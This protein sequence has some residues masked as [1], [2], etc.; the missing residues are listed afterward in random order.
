MATMHRKVIAFLAVLAF[1]LP[2][3]ACGGNDSKEGSDG[4][5]ATV[6]GSTVTVGLKEFAIST[7]RA[8]VPA[9]SV[10]FEA[11]NEGPEDE[12]E[13]VVIKTDLGVVG[14][15]TDATGTVDE[16]GEGVEALGEIE[17]F[18]V[19]ET[20]DLTL[21]LAP[22]NYVLICNIYT[23]SENESHYQEGMRTA[24]TVT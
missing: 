9:G 11:T 5:G 7:S 10:T 22:G 12:H 6:E 8:S 3:T 24:F 4:G 16:E 1:G 18:G 17:E 21:N 13:M 20:K 2:L 14:L 15:P 23:K 19:D